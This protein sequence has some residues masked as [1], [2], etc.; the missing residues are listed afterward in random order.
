VLIARRHEQFYADMRGEFGSVVINKVPEVVMRD[1]SFLRPCAQCADG[2]FAP[3]RK[4]PAGAQS[5]DA[6]AATR[7]PPPAARRRRRRC[8]AAGRLVMTCN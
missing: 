1:A 6:D 7:R 2:R 4:N 8:R 3:L 5:G